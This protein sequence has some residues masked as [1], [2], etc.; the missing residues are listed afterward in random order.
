[1][2]E[3]VQLRCD[4]KLHGI[5]PSPRV[6]EVACDSRYC[7]AAKGVV[8][9]HRFD[10]DSGQLVE[11]LRFKSPKQPQGGGVANGHL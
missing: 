8:V 5:I 10:I 2:Q 9:L 3:G 11:T 1:M 4:H 6:V 7:G